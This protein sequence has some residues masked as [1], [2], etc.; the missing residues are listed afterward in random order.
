MEF[1]RSGSGV[2][3]SDPQSR[4]IHAINY[5][6]SFHGRVLI[7]SADVALNYGQRY[8]PARAR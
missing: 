3:S 6:L 4:D 8:V 5:T 1:E 7:D 2:M